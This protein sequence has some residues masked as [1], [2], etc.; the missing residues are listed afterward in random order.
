MIFLTGDRQSA[1]PSIIR[2]LARAR[3]SFWNASVGII[4]RC[5][6]KWALEKLTARPRVVTSRRGAKKQSHTRVLVYGPGKMR[7]KTFVYFLFMTGEFGKCNL[8]RGLC[9]GGVIGR[10][11]WGTLGFYGVGILECVFN[12]RVEFWEFWM[13][14]D[15]VL[16]IIL[17]WNFVVKMKEFWINDEGIVDFRNGTGKFNFFIFFQLMSIN[18]CK[19]K[20]K[21]ICFLISFL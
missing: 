19:Q 3:C 21:L 6:F 14:F 8:F 1:L 12:L 15:F 4:I 5:L 7:W 10:V 17:H 11:V 18:W 9:A 2:L 16:K 20:A 13:L